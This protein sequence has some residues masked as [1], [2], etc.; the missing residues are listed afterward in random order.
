M[1]IA[2]SLLTVGLQFASHQ[3]TIQCYTGKAVASWLQVTEQHD[4]H[5]D[6][7]GSEDQGWRV[8]LRNAAAGS[9]SSLSSR[10]AQAQAWVQSRLPKR[11]QS[12][13]QLDDASKLKR[14]GKHPAHSMYTG[15]ESIGAAVT[16]ASRNSIYTACIY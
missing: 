11:D 4:S 8:R 7:K 14:D 15:V 10:A 16:G 13:E 3:N 5:R 9:A 12:K 2:G 6:G 1:T